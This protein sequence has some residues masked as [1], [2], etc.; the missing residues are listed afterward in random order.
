MILLLFLFQKPD[1]LRINDSMVIQ[2]IKLERGIYYKVFK[3][4]IKKP[5]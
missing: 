2:R 5:H 3:D 4:T 1:T